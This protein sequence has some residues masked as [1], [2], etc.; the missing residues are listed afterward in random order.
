MAR[1]TLVVN[2][3]DEGSETFLH[4]LASH[5]SELGHD[6]TV[7][8]L[9]DGRTLM[10]TGR[11]FDSPGLRRSSALP[12]IRSS[13]FLV[14]LA[15]LALARP[16]EFLTAVR[17]AL[18]TF[19]PNGRGIRAAFVA[20]PLLATDP[21]VVHIAFSGIAVAMSDSLSLL[22][23]RTR[24]IVSCRGS[25]ELVAPRIHSEL[26]PPLAA[27][28]K[29]AD[30]VHVVADVVADA[31]ARLGVPGDLITVIRPAV[32]VDEFRP[33]DRSVRAGMLNVLTVA[34]LHWIKGIDVQIAAAIQL[35]AEGL[36][37]RWT[38][39]GD[40]PD[41][42]QLELR[43]QLA[44]IDG[45]MTFVGALAPEQLRDRLSSADVFVSTSW[46]E[47][48]A[49]SVLE[50]MA[51]GVPVVSSAAGGMPEVLTDGV[52]A[53]LFPVGDVS[54]LVAAIREV[55]EDGDAAADMG[56]EG[57]RRVIDGLTTRQQKLEWARLY[58]NVLAPVSGR[59]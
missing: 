29:R 58:G 9:L 59:K 38:V 43:A 30:S 14:R 26:G 39:V 41:R 12:E 49:N 36:A 23:D 35:A 1:V 6:V 51:F 19:G 34:R 27:I 32:D 8:G 15:Q 20:A 44:G 2:N 17:R 56:D 21:D 55:A 37:F 42:A 57:R 46:S 50:A 10:R 18:G 25:G 22:D 31:V 47:G 3:F 4:T 52:D 24:L 16:R 53:R 45:S 33:R 13:M 28:L 11:S 48:T 40:G 54:G 7:H 5:I